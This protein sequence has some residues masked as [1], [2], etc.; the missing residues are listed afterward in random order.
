MKNKKLEFKLAL[1]P[2][3][4]IKTLFQITGG[5]R[6]VVDMNPFAL[7]LIDLKFNFL[8]WPLAVIHV[9]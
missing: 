3:D 6:Y 9:L 8:K 5:N 7:T 1:I 4:K 2:P